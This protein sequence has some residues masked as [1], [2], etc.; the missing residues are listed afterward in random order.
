MESLKCLVKQTLLHIFQEKLK[1]VANKS[2]TTQDEQ[3]K[4]FLQRKYSSKSN[5]SSHNSF[6]HISYPKMQA[7]LSDHRRYSCNQ[8]GEKSKSDPIERIE[9]DSK[10]DFEDSEVQSQPKKNLRV[11]KMPSLMEMKVSL[12]Q[13]RR[14]TVQQTKKV[15]QQCVLRDDLKD[16]L[17]I[18]KPYQ[19]PSLC[20]QI[21]L[22]I[23][24]Y[25]P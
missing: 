25:T 23:P 21:S 8:L 19:R 10:E 24:K 18:Q 11:N 1:E 3:I 9:E 20:G 5:A 12:M 2:S 7:S 17:D 13:S 4:E 16:F 14:F 15:I 6:N 22:Q